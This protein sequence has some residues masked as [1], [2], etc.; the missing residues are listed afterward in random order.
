ME[1]TGNIF[2]YASSVVCV[3]DPP[4]PPTA[5]NGLCS[6]SIISRPLSN[7]IGLGEYPCS[8]NASSEPFSLLDLL[9]CPR[10]HGRPTRIRTFPTRSNLSDPSW[11]LDH[12]R[13]VDGMRVIADLHGGDL[14]NASAKAEFQEIKDR[15]D[16]DVSDC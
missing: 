1:F 6:G 14:E 8:S 12:D 10:A 2:G 15:V 16:F 13:D 9:L 4:R 3:L 7:R 11:L 5:L